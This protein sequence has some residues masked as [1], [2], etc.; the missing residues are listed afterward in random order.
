MP[1]QLGSTGA[2][3]GAKIGRRLDEFVIVI[4]VTFLLRRMIVVV[5]VVVMAVA[6]LM[7]RHDHLA[8]AIAEVAEAAPDR[9]QHHQRQHGEGGEKSLEERRVHQAG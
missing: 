9:E 6:L 8:R 3:G 1:F 4:F 7:D 5:E 2:G